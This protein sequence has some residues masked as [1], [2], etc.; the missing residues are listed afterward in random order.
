MSHITSS[1]EL[2]ESNT[3]DVHTLGVG[4]VV[5]I[6]RTDLER[7]LTAEEAEARLEEYGPNELEKRERISPLRIFLEQFTGFLVVILIVAALV[8][9]LI[10]EMVDAFA[11]LVI[12]VLN[13]IL[14]FVQEYKAERS[15]EALKSLETPEAKVIR[16][17]REREIAAR[18]LV[19]GDL[20]ALDEGDRIPADAR[21]TEASYLLTEE[22]ILTGESTPVSKDTAPLQGQVAIADQRNMVFSGCMIAKG[23]GR[24]LVVGTGMET[25]VGKIAHMVQTAE[26]RMTPLQLALD[27][28]GKTLGVICIAVAIPGFLIGVLEGRDRIEMFMMAVSLAVSAIPEGLPIVVTIALALGTK[29]MVERNALIRKLQI[30]EALGSTDVI[31]SDKTGTITHNKMTVTD[32]FIPSQGYFK[33]SG[34]GYSGEGEFWRVP[35]NPSR[36][37]LPMEK[38]HTV[39]SRE[40]IMQDGGLSL[41][42]KIGALCND[43]EADIG[44]PTER[45]LLFLAAKGELDYISLRR[46]H[47]RIDEIPFDSANKYMAVLAKEVREG[48]ENALALIKGAPEVVLDFCQY[49]HLNGQVGELTSQTGEEIQEITEDMSGRALRV[50]A[51]A[52]KEVPERGGFKELEGYIFVG[53]VG[54]LDPPREEVKPALRV[55]EEAGVRVVMITGDHKLTAKAIADQIGLDYRE[56]LTGEDLDRI[57]DQEFREVV[58][59]TSIFARVSPRH[60]VRILKALQENGHIVAMTGDG[61]NDAPAVKNADIGVVVGSGADLTKSI[62]DLILLD[63][64]FATISKAIEEGRHIFYNIKKFVRFLLS[65]NFDEIAEVLTSILLGIPLPFL[66]LQILWLNLATDSLPA[67][68]LTADTLDPLVMKRGPYVPRKEIFRGVLSFSLVAGLI[69]YVSTFGLFL[70]EYYLWGTPLDKAR[71]MAFTATVFFE[72]WVVFSCRSER[73]AF[74]IGIFSNKPLLLAIFAGV[75]LQLFAVY[76]PFAQPIFRTVPLGLLDWGKILVSSSAGFVVIE[77]ARA[78][79]RRVW[80]EV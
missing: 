61:V 21:L 68:A 47:Q 7:G 49:I 57:E 46:E 67:L 48:G 6:L 2:P 78:I 50:L 77:T 20:I 12:I 32:L 38:V 16:G 14:G 71:T 26:T 36:A 62:A 33:V 29:K 69:A 17:G 54:M 15:L 31:C 24:A 45:S 64:N 10:G 19:P 79:S 41:L 51:M 63:D 42:L 66:P 13:G 59:E 73:S 22:A 18:D 74:E 37:T 52:Y 4:Q 35:A 44:D 25:E 65:A 11:I 39:P 9:F 28:L 56:I 43:A 58:E 23:R 34:E 3:R 76:V 60:K 70:M 1:E 30:A 27:H 72:F 53:L 75:S 40:E 5:T 80:R 8:S 55:C